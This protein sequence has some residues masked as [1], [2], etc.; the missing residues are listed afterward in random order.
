MDAGRGRRTRPDEGRL[1]SIRLGPRDGRIL[2]LSTTGSRTRQQLG[3]GDLVYVSVVEGK[4]GVR[5]DLRSR[6][7][8]QGAVAVIENK[9]GRILAMAGG[10]SY[11]ASQLNRVSQTRRQ[12]G[13]SFKP[14]TYLAAL[15]A[16]LQ[17]NTL[18]DDSTFTLPPIGDS[19]YATDKDYWTPKNYDGGGG[20][21][22]TLRRGLENSKNLVTAHLLDGGVAYTPQASLDK[23]CQLAI[24]EGIYPK[25]ERYYPFILGAQPVRVLDMAAFYA[26]IA[27]EGVRPTPYGI[28]EIDQ[29]GKPIYQHT[30]RLTPI[31]NADKPAFYQ[32]KSMLQGVL[33]RGTARSIGAMSPYVGG[34]TGTSD[35]ENDAWFCGFSND[36]T[37]AVWVGYDNSGRT[38]RT[39][40][41]GQTGGHVAVPIFEPIM[42]AVWA[43]YAPK[44][45]LRGPSPEAQRHLVALPIDLNSGQRLEGRSNPGAFTE[46]FRLNAQG[47]LEDTQNKLSYGGGSIGTDGF[48]W[49]ERPFGG[50]NPFFGGNRRLVQRSAVPYAATAAA[51]PAPTSAAPA[52]TNGGGTPT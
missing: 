32:L 26:S 51:A 8:V 34:K 5:V 25:C 10:F 20:G 9:T 1:R 27:N 45:P 24:E 39:L 16:G 11:Q 17:P 23:V 36:V 28:E 38:R 43:N 46:W 41:P 13:S 35:D 33:A 15:N 2:P 30:P 3:S 14:M 21:I 18:V 49:G 48:Y 22:S 29:D 50:D 40:G 37:I 42:Q 31:T 4:Q 19:R 47:K 44:T 12:P 7:K 6:P 52:A